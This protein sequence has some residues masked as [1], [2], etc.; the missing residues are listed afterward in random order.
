MASRLEYVQ[1]VAEQLS[2]A[3]EITYKKMF[4][5]YGL[6]CDGK[7]FANVSDDQLFVK[8]TEAGRR[9]FPG[10][11]EAPPYP[12][13]K[14]YLLIENVDDRDFLTALTLTTCQALPEPKKKRGK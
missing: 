8:I 3:G 4:G 10:L 11:P 7:I 12:G 6:Y 5:E 9:L 2:G 1:Y 13:A 14:D